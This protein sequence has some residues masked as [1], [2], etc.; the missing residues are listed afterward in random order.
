[1]VFRPRRGHGFRLSYRRK[2]R[3]RSGAGRGFGG[4]KGYIWC[5]NRGV[6]TIS[7]T[8]PEVEALVLELRRKQT[9]GQRM[10]SG[11]EMSEFVRSLEL[12]V[13]RKQNP[14]SDEADLRYLLTVKRY[15]REM[16]RKAFGVKARTA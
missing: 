11:F 8:T 7:D 14:D 4:G 12:G 1:M 13:L 16:A 15:G 5:D 10:T 2:W 6:R 9:P 3:S